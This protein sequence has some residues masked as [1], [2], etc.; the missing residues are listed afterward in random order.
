MVRSLRRLGALVFLAATV[1]S[2]APGCTDNGVSLFIRQCQALPAD[3]CSVT[4]DA[5]QAFISEGLLDVAFNNNYSCPLLVG[6]QLVARGDPAKVRAE[7]SRIQIY[8]ADVRILDANG[9]PVAKAD[10][11]AQEF[12][13]PTSGFADP[14]TASS[15]GFGLANIVL[16][17]VQT[18]S[19]QLV[20]HPGGV[21]LI[22]AVT[23]HGRTLGGNEVT[24]AEWR[25]PIQV[26]PRTTS[27]DLSPCVSGDNDKPKPN[28]H[29]GINDAVDCR[30]GCPCE[31][32]TTACLPLGCV[33]G[34]CGACQANG[35]GQCPAGTS[36]QG[37]FCQ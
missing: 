17:D 29:P 30:L 4:A 10:G 36:C 6:N 19:Q 35:K 3:T 37:G 2:L 7:T 15:P 13:T 34:F 32:G 18:A 12:F 28:C 16:L 26:V 25:F 33:A 24:S 27:C 8:G 23:L 14:G 9:D 20:E 31:A 22:S 11:S 1:G 5:S 21:I